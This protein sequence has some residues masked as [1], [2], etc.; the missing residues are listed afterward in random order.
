MSIKAVFIKPVEYTNVIFVHETDFFFIL[1]VS[2]KSKIKSISVKKS[3]ELQIFV[4]LI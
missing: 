2:I 3:Q 4:F 1:I